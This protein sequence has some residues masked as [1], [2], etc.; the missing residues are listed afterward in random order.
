[1]FLDARPAR[2]AA[3]ALRGCGACTIVPLSAETLA[4]SRRRVPRCRCGGREPAQAADAGVR[5]IDLGVRLRDQASRCIQKAAGRALKLT[6]RARREARLVANPGALCCT[7]FESPLVEPACCPQHRRIVTPSR[8]YRAPARRR[9]S[10]HFQIHGTA[11]TACSTTATAR[12]EQGAGRQVTF[13]PAPAGADRPRHPGDHLRARRARRT[14]RR[15]AGARARHSWRDV[16]AAG[17]PCCRDKH[18]AHT[19]F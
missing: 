17:R 7:P 2:R 14:E 16:R 15:S 5:V 6:K 12:I 9:R 13:T 11:L 3:A 18:V 10:G 1:M 8:A 4:R 19:N